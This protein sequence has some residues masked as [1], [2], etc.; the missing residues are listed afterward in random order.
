MSAELPESSRDERDLQRALRLIRL[1]RD[2]ALPG[3]LLMAALVVAGFAAITIGYFGAAR[4]IYVPLQMPEIV[5]GGVGGLAL[6]G[7]GAYLFGV[8]IDRRHAAREEMLTDEML[9]EMAD[10]VA[11][12]PRLR[13]IAARRRT[14]DR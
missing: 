9:G 14:A 7:V 2:P 4:L 12:S 11:L 3:L 13:D 8:Q 6:I 1:L 5:S 10:L